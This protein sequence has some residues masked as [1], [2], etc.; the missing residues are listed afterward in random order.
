VSSPE[1]RIKE[2]VRARGID[3]ADAASLLAAVRPPAPAR[4]SLDPFAR[5]SGE[6]TSLLGGVVALGALATSRLGVRYD[7]AIDL[8]VSPAGAVAL[9]LALGDLVVSVPLTALVFFLAARRLARHVR[10][11]DVLGAVSLARAPIVLAAAPLALLSRLVG[12]PTTKPSAALLALACVGLLGLGGH[13]TLLVLGFRSASGARGGRLA[14]TFVAAL[15]VS[16]IAAKTVLA[17]LSLF[18]R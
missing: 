12:A 8:H 14:G 16:E 6:V 1:E 18:L 15:F 9:P 5:W 7:G 2:L 13:I 11:V 4:S 10:F 17:L 3:E